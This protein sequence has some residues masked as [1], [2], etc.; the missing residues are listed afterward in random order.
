[1]ESLSTL[2]GIQKEVTYLKALGRQIKQSE[3]SQNQGVEDVK[4]AALLG[5]D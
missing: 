2:P 5:K 3:L 1:V 4:E